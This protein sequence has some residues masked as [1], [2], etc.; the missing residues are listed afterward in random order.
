MSETGMLVLANGVLLLY[1]L[2]SCIFMTQPH[3]SGGEVTF[4][5]WWV[6][7]FLLCVCADGLLPSSS[8]WTSGRKLWCWSDGRNHHPAR[9]V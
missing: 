2:Q 8:C 3:L 4:F 7:V 6:I 1:N 5:L 9:F